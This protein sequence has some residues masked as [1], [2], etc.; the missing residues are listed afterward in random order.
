MQNVISAIDALKI[1]LQTEEALRQ[2]AETEWANGNHNGTMKQAHDIS[3]QQVIAA[4]K[5][6]AN[7]SDS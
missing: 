1:V 4:A 7:L 5:N 3:I 6:L 2:A